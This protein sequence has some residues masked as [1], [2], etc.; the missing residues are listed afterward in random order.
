MTY[1][2]PW[3]TFRHDSRNTGFSEQIADYNPAAPWDKP[4]FF[5]TGKGIFST[6]VIGRDGTIYVGSADHV[7]YAV[8]PDGSLQWQVETG[9]IID[10]AGAIT[11]NDEDERVTFISGDGKMYQLRTGELLDSTREVWQF[12]AELRPGV[13]F[14]R[15]FEGNVAVG[16]DGTLYAGNTNF[17]YYALS[18]DGKLKWTYPTGSNNWSQAAFGE[19]GSIYWGSLDTFIRKV[20]AQGKEIWRRRTLGFVAASAAIGSDGT[21]YIGSF[22]SNLYALNPHSGRVMW[23]FSTGDHIYSSAALSHDVKGQTSTIYIASTDG[24]LYALSPEGSLLWQYDT[25]DPIRSSPAVGKSPDGL[26]DIIYFGC[27]NGFLYAINADG[28]L[29]WAYDSN[30]SDPE[31]SDRNDLNSSPA[32]GKFGVYIGGE[33]GRLVY[34]PYDYPLLNNTE[35]R[36][37]VAEYP[38]DFCGLFYVSPGGNT[39]I[40]FP[41]ELP[42]SA[43]ITLRLVVRQHGKTTTARLYNSPIGAPSDALVVK[44]EPPVRCEVDHSADGR[45][46]YIRPQDFFQPGQEYKLHASGR[47]YT[48]GL[49]VGN[50]TLGGRFSGRFASTFKFQV[51]QTSDSLPIKIE[52]SRI[53]ALEWTRLAAPI[54]AMLPSLNQI[55]FDYIEWLIAPVIIEQPDEHGRGRMV[56][57]AIGAK[58]SAEG[59]LTPDPHSDFILP[60][61]GCYQGADF[62]LHNRGFP[63]AITGITIPFN[64]FELRGRFQKD[65]STF[66]PA[67]YADTQALSIPTFGPYLVI[68][69]LANNWFQKLLVAGTFVT[70]RYD[71]PS[72][73]QQIHIPIK[74]INYNPPSR[75][76]N[77]LMRAEFQTAGDAPFPMKDHSAGILL[78]DTARYEAV[79]LDYKACLSTQLDAQGCLVS[80]SLIIPKETKLPT[81]LQ[82]VVMLDLFT[83]KQENLIS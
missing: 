11:I 41:S 62:I 7:F 76:A 27:G 58:K 68:A 33:H 13:S 21:V 44:F 72:T 81:T 57:W 82:G 1:S 60:L 10:S 24:T 26:A 59:K 17:M 50:L 79:A 35:E 45:F 8:N 51:P 67:A 23:K 47:Y 75:T 15:W 4:W 9:E 70:R 63:M 42:A 18:T 12:E 34:V 25:G 32:L 43:M 83:I 37:H 20:S 36:N 40:E 30:S 2:S 48:G 14:N 54:P 80:I 22:D 71:I 19:D 53:D 49:R 78:V 55:G 29:R 65:G 28:T 31:L 3:P 46:V 73:R 61:S 38:A 77:G 16:P 64:L 39:Q 66:L 56:M 74:S 6:P 69:G 52:E 5:H